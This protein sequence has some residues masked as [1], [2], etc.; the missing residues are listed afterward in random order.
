MS[1]LMKAL[2]SIFFSLFFFACIVGGGSHSPL[3]NLSTTEEDTPLR[4]RLKESDEKKQVICREMGV[5]TC[6]T[7]E[8]EDTC[9][10]TFSRTSDKKKCLGLPLELVQDFADL[11]EFLSEGDDMQK[12]EL[13]V[14][15]CLLDIDEKPFVRKIKKLN[16][17]KT[18]DFLSFAAQNEELG[19]ILHS[20]D[21]EHLL[22][23]QLF[24]N[25]SGQADDLKKLELHIDG[26]SH[27]LELIATEENRET[28][29][30]IENFIEEECEDSPLCE[31]DEGH[32][33][34]IVFYCRLFL[35]TARGRLRSIMNSSLFERQIGREMEEKDVC[36]A[37]G[38]EECD[39]RYMDDFTDFCASYTSETSL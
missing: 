25:L 5:Q 9:K 33:N 31:T 2:C 8:C 22:L 34:S 27:I 10:D 35:D 14:L 36:G 26:G 6:N 15:E 19:D 21:D 18:R 16:R 32:K 1:I 30:W 38:K 24:N 13:P 37:N 39:P 3:T 20:E 23:K 12:I 11:L 4:R 29:D 7:I 17:E 28:W